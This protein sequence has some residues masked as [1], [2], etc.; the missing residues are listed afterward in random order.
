VIN[1]YSLKLKIIMLNP[2]FL[3]DQDSNLLIKSQTLAAG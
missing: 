3:I 2:Q 1:Y